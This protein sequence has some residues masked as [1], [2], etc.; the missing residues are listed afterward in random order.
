M[1]A[2]FIL[3]AGAISRRAAAQGCIA[4]PNNPCSH[5]GA[6]RVHN[7]MSLANRWLGSVDYRWYESFVIFKGTWKQTQ[8]EAVETIH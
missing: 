5:V 2:T 1:A 7:T 4:S 8:R 6:G 3:M